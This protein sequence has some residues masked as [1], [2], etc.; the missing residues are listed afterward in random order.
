MLGH[1][2]H[3]HPITS[4]TGCEGTITAPADA[5]HDPNANIFGV[6]DAE[7]TDGGGGGQA[8]LTSH[9]QVQLQPRHRQAEHFTG[10]SG[11]KIQDKTSANGGKTVGD[12]NN[13]DWISFKPYNLTGS[14]TLT[15]RISS[16]GS[17]GFLEVR[18]GSATGNLLGS[19]PIPVTGSWDTFQDIDVPLRAVPKKTTELFLVFKG[20]DGAPVRPGRLHHQ[21]LR[22]RQDGETRPGLLQDR[23][24][25][26]RRHPRG[27]R[28]DQ[29]ARQGQQHHRRHH[30][31]GGAVHH[32][33]P[34]Q[35]RRGRLPVHDR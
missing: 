31:R 34:R 12:I 24:V 13:D 15:A 32:E 1:D 8:A 28:R 7:Y 27:H 2:S 20:G 5:D 10:S 21:R 35:V 25:P 19:A 26:A 17:G 9:A 33:Q 18:T 14:K 6:L 22:A 29:G 3:G 4:A 30:G 16:A 11:I 23:G